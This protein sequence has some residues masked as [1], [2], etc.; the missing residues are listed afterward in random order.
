MMI[1]H[2]IF[3]IILM[4]ILLTAFCFPYYGT[5]RMIIAYA[6]FMTRVRR[7]CRIRL[8]TIRWVAMY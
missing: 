5:D 2:G 8:S 6:L 7:L 3:A 1:K 4:T